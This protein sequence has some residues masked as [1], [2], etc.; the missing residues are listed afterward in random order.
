MPPASTK[1]PPRRYSLQTP[2]DTGWIALS[3]RERSA[4]GQVLHRGPRFLGLNLRPARTTAPE[5]APPA[6]R[7]RNGR[8]RLVR[9]RPGRHRLLRRHDV[10][11][12]VLRAGH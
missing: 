4:D 10:A 8:E 5:V 9:I 11:G 1:R 2:P 7:R 6:P 12:R 3:G